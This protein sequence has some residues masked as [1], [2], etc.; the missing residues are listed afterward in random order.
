MIASATGGVPP[1]RKT[2]YAFIDGNYLEIEYAAVMKAVH[3]D[4]GELDYGKLRGHLQASKLFYYDAVGEPSSLGAN[5]TSKQAQD[6]AASLVRYTE[7]VARLDRIESTPA[8][9]VRYGTAQNR[10]NLRRNPEQEQ[11]EVDVLLAV[12]ALMFAV[13]GNMTDVALISG[14]LDFRP[15]VDA[16]VQLGIDVTVWSANRGSVDLRR[17]ADT[18][19]PLD[20]NFCRSVTGD[21]WTQRHP[22]VN[23]FISGVPNYDVSHEEASGIA[24]GASAHCGFYDNTFLAWVEGETLVNRCDDKDALLRHMTVWRGVAWS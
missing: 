14:D 12:E 17:A 7:K 16:L 2:V 10:K 18:F 5:P 15:V 13:R 11:K 1:P 8:F 21:A 20:Y 6:H 23:G 3:L 22:M 24:S 4:P 9:H 19:R